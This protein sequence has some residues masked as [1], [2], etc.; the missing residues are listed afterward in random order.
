[1][2]RTRGKVR[3]DYGNELAVVRTRT[4]WGALILLLALL[5]AL[6]HLLSLTGNASWLT[7]VNEAG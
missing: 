7:F 6:P 1:M 3:V 2:A 4:Q 5:A